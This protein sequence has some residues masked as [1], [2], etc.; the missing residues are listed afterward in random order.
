M[1]NLDFDRH[2]SPYYPP[3]AKWYSGA[4]TLGD[5]LGRR[6]PWNTGQ[7]PEMATGA[8]LAAFLVPGLGILL[9]GRKRL[10][11]CAIALS[12]CLM[13][14]FIVWL[15]YPAG[16][17]AFG[18]LI[19][20]HVTSIGCY[21]APLF[22]DQSFR[23]R[24]MF[25]V[26]TLLAISTLIYWPA[27]DFVQ[28]HWLMPLRVNGNVIVLHRTTSYRFIRPGDWV[29]YRITRSSQ[30]MAHGGNGE[31]DVRSGMGLGPVLAMP[32]D[33]IDFTPKTFLVNGVE[34]PRLDNMPFSGSFVVP[35]KHWFI[36]P[37]FGV[38]NHNVSILVLNQAALDMAVVPW[39]HLVGKP[40][41]TWLWRK[42][43][44]I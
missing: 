22:T 11:W 13:V 36:W 15:G 41:H 23:Q 3:R 8:L 32:G 2:C 24:V 9:T 33:Q 43:V 4:L 25:T 7:F 16:N 34:Y 5:S 39:E 18:W 19:S 29:G 1:A 26:L 30:G 42:Q 40:F 6:M 44:L 38:A 27:R 10:G 12:F 14:A 31:V 35:E 20:L 17:F 21:C 28:E 37:R